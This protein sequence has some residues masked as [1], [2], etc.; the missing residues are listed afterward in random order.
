MKKNLYIGILKRYQL[1]MKFKNNLKYDT[2]IL[3][4]YTIAI[5]KKTEVKRPLC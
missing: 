4:E 1:K 3:N 2:L 5:K